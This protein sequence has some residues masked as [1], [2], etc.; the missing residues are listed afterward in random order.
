[1]TQ[2]IRIVVPSDSQDHQTWSMALAYG[3]KL[4]AD[5]P[6]RFDRIVLVVHTQDQIKAT[7]LGAFLGKA[8]QKAL[9]AGRP[10]PTGHGPS[11]TLLTKA[12]LPFTFS[13][14]VVIVYFADDG[15]LEQLDGIRGLHGIVVVPDHPASVTHWVDRWN[16][17][18]HGAPARREAR[19]I[20]DPVIERALSSV[21][22]MINLSHS[23]MNPRDKEYADHALRILRANGHTADSKQIKSWAIKNGWHPKAADELSALSARILNMASL[24]SLSKIHDAGGKYQRWSSG[25]E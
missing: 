25:E 16:P 10:V 8:V 17:K 23:V 2:T 9:L 13:K 18:I 1:M 5:H 12:K 20:E 11:L 3:L 6:D 24:P 19:L 21:T 22:G 15:L 14:T 4:C 7:A